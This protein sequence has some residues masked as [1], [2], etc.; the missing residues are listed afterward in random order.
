MPWSSTCI[1]I[2]VL[3]LYF[4]ITLLNVS[5]KQVTLKMR[6]ISESLNRYTKVDDRIAEK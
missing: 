4:M 2:A 1:I 3:F 6:I 5:F